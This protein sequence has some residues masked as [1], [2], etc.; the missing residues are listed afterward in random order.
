MAGLAAEQD[1]LLAAHAWCLRSAGGSEAA[2][3]LIAG[4][5]RYWVTSA[6]LERGH[7]LAEAA[8][9]L[10]PA[11]ANERWRGR[12]I[13]A[14]GQ[15]AF[16][17]GRY[18]ESLAHADAGLAIAV[19][20]G[21]AEQIAAG[22][23]LRAKGLHS[24]GYPGQ[25]L[26]QYEQACEVART[27]HNSAW[28]GTALNNLAELHRSEGNH[29]RAQA[30][31]EEAIGIARQRQ[32]PEGIFVPLCN[33]ARLSLSCG[34]GERAHALLLESLQLASSAE[35]KGMGEDVL[36]VAAGLASVR[37]HYEHAARFAGAALSR[38]RESGSQREPVDEAFVAPLVEKARSALGNEGFAAAQAEGGAWTHDAAIHQV[39]QWLEAACAI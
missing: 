4:L 28:L 32:S 39:R 24:T 27:L 8:L 16:R 21:D 26:L 30:C 22:L 35:L 31:Y 10:A 12:A 13:W 7:A 18:S 5:W 19:A 1:N 20:Q 2:L 9:A 37:Q 15:I 38:M 25:A 3:R 17:M 11:P 23:G 29:A 14:A 36:E 6:Q 33:L 34:H